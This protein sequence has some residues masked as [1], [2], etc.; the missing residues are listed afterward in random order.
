M[1]RRREWRRWVWVIGRK[2]KTAV[3]GGFGGDRKE[4]MGERFWE[5]VVVERAILG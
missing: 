2:G 4:G 1:G 3:E 5:R